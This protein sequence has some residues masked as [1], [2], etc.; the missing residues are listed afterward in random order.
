MS[1]NA[2][3]L[4][5]AVLVAAAAS[6]PCGCLA[7]C[8]A[9]Q[10]TASG[11]KS[12]ATICSGD[13]IF[14][15]DFEDFDLSV[16]QHEITMSGGGNG[17]F[18]IYVNNRSNSFARDGYLN[19]RPT[20]TSDKYGEAFLSSGTIDL[21]GGSPADEC[22]N[23]LVNGCSRTGTATNILNPVTSARVRTV[24]SFSFLYGRV[25]VRAKMPAG[26]WLWPAIWLL[27]RYNKYG[28]WPASGEVDLLEA[29]GNLGLTLGDTNIGA[30]QVGST[31]HFGPYYPLDAYKTATFSQNSAAG[32]GYDKDFHSYQL[33]WTPDYMKFSID[34][35][36]IGTVTP[37]DEG[38]WSYGGF[39]T[40]LPAAEN[41]WRYA[42]KMAPF[43][44]EYY[45]IINLAIGGTN[46]Y[47]PDYALNAGGNK[48]WI[49]TSPTALTDFWNGRDRWLPT[50][51]LEEGGA[52][53]L[54]VDYV[55]V[56]AL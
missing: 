11:T 51:N 27:P 54:Q 4:L 44:Q 22:T 49:N 9:S 52:S 55:R 7:Q 16:W 46:G 31:L 53:S 41:P 3:A 6:L 36:E 26:D 40:D 33:E 34:G 8:T 43:D 5:V 19:I 10:T 20:L 17:E 15:D 13:M 29:R 14:A 30:E 32:Q 56:W 28:P 25:E 42:T 48:P 21:N 47:F 2:H 24:N 50:W 18:E 37:T 1:R 12:P 39:N 35:T 45:I 38:F 23:P